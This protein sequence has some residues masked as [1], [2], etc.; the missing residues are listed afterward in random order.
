[1]SYYRGRF[2]PSASG[3]LHIGSI[4]AAL[5]SYLDAQF[6]RGNWLIRIDDLD[7]K[8]CRS[9]YVDQALKC[10]DAFGLRSDHPVAYQTERLNEYQ[11]AFLTLN[12]LGLLYS[13]DCSRKSLPAGPYSGTC[14]HR[15][16]KPLI[17]TLA[18]RINASGINLFVN[19]LIMGP[20]I[21]EP[22]G[23]FI[24]KRR[25]GLFSYQL[26]C[27]IDE[28]IDGI[29]FVIRGVDLLDSSP[30]QSLIAE[31]L[32]YSSPK[33]GHFPVLLGPDSSKLSKQTFAQ[34]VNWDEPGRTYAQLAS[35]LLQKEM[36]ETTE[37][38]DSWL[39]YFMTLGNPRELIK[40]FLRANTLSL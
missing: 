40:G 33:Y 1:M 2:A 35:L 36:P 29:T 14:R 12:E 5:I 17:D 19:D 7:E 37:S 6:N 23:D 25:D 27:A 28:Q 39:N 38:P 30:R 9:L 13:C 20:R 16:G 10:L 8:R 11:S 22:H 24:V 4:F 32:G 31:V 18:T 34:A 15:L 3:P 21:T 26:A